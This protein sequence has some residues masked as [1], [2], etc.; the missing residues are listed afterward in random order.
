MRICLVTLDFPPFRSSGLTI[1]AENL[2]RGLVARGHEVTVVAADR[3]AAAGVDEIPMPAAVRVVRVPV[4]R[5]DWIGLGWQAARY[6]MGQS[7][8]FDVVHFTDVHF[9]YAYHRPYVATAWQSFRQRLTS[10]GG[11]PYHTNWRNYLFRRSYY[12]GARWLMEFHSTRRARYLVMPSQATRAEFLQH[13]GVN[14]NRAPLVYPGLDL[15]RFRTLPGKQA[16]RELLCLCGETPVVLYVGFS[17]PRKGVEHLARALNAMPPVQLLMVGKW[18]TGY[19]EIFEKALGE[20][21]S[22]T[23]MAGYVRQ[24]DIL[25]YYAAADV[26]VLPSL[27][28]GVGIPPIEAMA[29][30]IPVVT[31]TGGAA[32]EVVGPA[33]IVVAPADSTALAAGLT[34]VL[35]D[36]DLARQLG[37]AGRQRACSL[38]DLA[39]ASQ[40]VETI[41]LR[42]LEMGG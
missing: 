10:A 36:R 5:A 4:G 7:G 15:E 27:L 9:A 17:T 28:E 24:N 40:R 8:R 19:R 33:G 32:G 22:R 20:A 25:W 18:E 39:A 2:A 16:A 42:L 1:Y 6:L 38:F 21:R 31:T 35:G 37:E 11:K 41:Y 12:T 29:A 34:R 14:P 3:P 26:L 23:I 30:G 13:Y